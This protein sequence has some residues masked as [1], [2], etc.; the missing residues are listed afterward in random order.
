MFEF[1]PSKS[2]SNRLK[3]GIDFDEAKLLWEVP[4][5]VRQAAFTG[6]QR[7]LLIAKYSGKI[8]AAIYTMR[9]QKVRVI[10]VRRARKNEEELFRHEQEE[11]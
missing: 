8:W 1:D 3:H 7:W 5:V 4:G 9:G 6:E 2:K 11:N 10:S